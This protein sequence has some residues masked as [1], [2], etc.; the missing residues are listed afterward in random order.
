MKM[1]I[2]H[3]G[4]TEEA[5]KI[6]KAG[7]DAIELHIKEIMSFDDAEFET[8]KKRIKDSGLA[9]E[10]FDNPLP[11]DVVIAEDTFD[12]QY[13]NEY[14]KKAVFRT[15]QMGARYFVYGTAVPEVFR[16]VKKEKKQ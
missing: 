10:V 9:S 15:S 6:A 11:L 5:D 1:R 13:Y 2:S 14:L 4:F 7:Y 8:A 12:F 16:K 3:F